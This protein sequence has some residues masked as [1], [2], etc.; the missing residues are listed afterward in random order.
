MTNNDGSLY[1]TQSWFAH[2]R[3]PASG[4][5]VKVCSWAL[6]QIPLG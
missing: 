5:W 2:F 6:A 3:P 1:L 4:I